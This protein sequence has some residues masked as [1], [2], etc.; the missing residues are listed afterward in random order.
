MFE[1]AIERYNLVVDRFTFV[2]ALFNFAAVGTLAIFFQKG[3][4]TFVTQGYLVATSVILAW[5]LSHFNPWTSWAL[6]VMLA[7]YDLCA[8][9]TPCG[10]LRALVNLMSQEGSPN[11]PGLLYEAEL[12]AEAQRPGR[13]RRQEDQPPTSPSQPSSSVESPSPA[14]DENPV[15]TPSTETPAPPA[16]PDSPSPGGTEE[17]ESPAPTGLM[18]LAIAKLYRL[19]LVEPVSPTRRPSFTPLLEEDGITDNPSP[20][21]L[22]AR[23]YTP[24]QLCMEVE[25]IF[26]RNGGRIDRTV[27]ASGETRYIVKDRHGEVKKTLFVDPEGKVF[28]VRRRE[29]TDDT[30]ENNTIK[31]GLGDFIFYSVLVSNAVMYS[32]TTF[33]ACMLVILAGLGGTLVLLAVFQHALPALPISIFL[34]VIFYLLTRLWIEPWIEAVFERPFYV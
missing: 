5:Q 3:I 31:L 24:E 33:A 22:L 8:V 19:P 20:N 1:V 7:L 21:E 15:S 18:P 12:P 14:S 13:R 34:G 27:T 26:P 32:F 28:E 25:A 30:K 29:N 11:M 4:P 6:L 2:F 17:D 16:S 9:L 23:Q 10:P